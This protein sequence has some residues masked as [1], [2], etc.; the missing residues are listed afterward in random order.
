M[1]EMYEVL[2]QLKNEHLQKSK[3]VQSSSH[4][5]KEYSLQEDSFT[6]LIAEDNEV[7]MYLSKILVQQLAP[8]ST[9][10]E[11]KDGVEAVNLFFEIRPDFVL[12]DIQMPN[13]NGIQATQQIRLKEE[14]KST[15]IVALTAGNMSGEKERC[16]EAGMDDFMSKPI[17]K[18]DLAN[19]LKKWLNPEE[20]EEREEAYKVE[21]IEHLNKA[22]FHQYA[23]GD[24][25]FKRSFIELAKTGLEESAK[26]L[27]K[28]ILEKDL[29]AL[30]ATGHKLKG[31]SLAVG[32]PQLS[33]LAI[34]FELL[35]DFDDEY[36]NNLF[37]SVLFE[38]RIVNKLLLN[39][40]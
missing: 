7:N 12:M 27:Q 3:K 10:V 1:Q 35:D 8:N 36:V 20:N 40:Y 31:T 21:K 24:I 38:I 15:P 17:V 6:I 22:W 23:S 9:I 11:A 2:G 13:M 4:D 26:A 34:A 32:L 25:E 18:K 19:L 30:N 37:E 5:T 14:G 16:L 33:K 39:E 29:A 28:G